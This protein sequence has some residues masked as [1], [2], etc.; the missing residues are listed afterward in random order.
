MLNTD[1]GVNTEFTLMNLQELIDKLPPEDREVVLAHFI[2]Y[3]TGKTSGP[4]EVVL[5]RTAKIFA[6]GTEDEIIKDVANSLNIPEDILRE[7]NIAEKL[8]SLSPRAAKGSA[9][10]S[11]L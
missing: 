2:D 8:K 7:Q 5:R 10:Y 4:K 11:Q 6:L 3:I 1:D 9:S